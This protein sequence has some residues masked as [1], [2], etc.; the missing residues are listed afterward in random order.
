LKKGGRGGF[1]R[2]VYQEKRMEG[3]EE[4]EAY[5]ETAKKLGEKKRV[6]IGTGE[7]TSQFLEPQ[8]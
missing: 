6:R 2:E 4:R 7:E 5:K 1:N 8:G 3:G